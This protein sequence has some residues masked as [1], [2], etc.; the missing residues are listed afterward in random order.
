MPPL[1]V[2]VFSA[3]VT[4]SCADDSSFKDSTSDG[5][6]SDDGDDSGT[7]DIDGTVGSNHG[8]EVTI[9]AA[10]LDAGD[11]VTL[12]LTTGSGHTHIFTI[13]AQ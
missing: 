12:T 11:A 5:S 6:Y 8:H 1:L 10:E 7:G 13:T 4:L 2:A 9:T 3:V